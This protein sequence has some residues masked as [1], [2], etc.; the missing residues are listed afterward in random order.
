MIRKVSIKQGSVGANT[1]RNTSEPLQREIIMPICKL[2]EMTWEDVDNL[3]RDQTI[4][5]IPISPIEAHGP[6]LPLGTDI[7]AARDIADRAAI[8]VTAQSPEI[9]AV[10][11]NPIPLGCAMTAADFPGTISLSGIAMKLVV[12]DVVRSFVRHGFHNIIIVNHHLDPIHM[13]AILSAIDEISDLYSA[14]IA[15]LCSRVTYTEIVTKETE[16]IQAMGLNVNQELHAD[17]K[18]TSFIKYRYPELLRRNF[19][20]LPPVLLDVKECMH[21]GCTTFRQM[22][23]EEAYVG[24]PAASTKELGRLHLEE[25]GQLTAELA[26]KLL[27]GHSLPEIHP[28]ILKFLKRKVLLE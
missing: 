26:L 5:F 11:G 9:S 8:I 25:Y 14:R 17:I 24:S 2:D 12:F 4:I 23:A 28:R 20:D 1:T 21:Q 6:H 7:F 16:M 15:E 10:L 18:E 3:K 27:N 19:V 13:K 22:G